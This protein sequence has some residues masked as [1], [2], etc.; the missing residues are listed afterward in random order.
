M[1]KATFTWKAKICVFLFA[2]L[3]KG[4]HTQTFETN[5]E[6]QN[7]ETIRMDDRVEKLL[8]DAIFP[9]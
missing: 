8:I 7:K 1:S 4:F 2:F 9:T 3:C 5:T 6:I